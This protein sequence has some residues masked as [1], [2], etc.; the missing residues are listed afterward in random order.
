LY[1][2]FNGVWP[3]FFAEQF[4]WPVRYSGM[5]LGNQFGLVLA[6]FGP[7]IAGML[8]TPGINGWVPVATFGTICMLVAALSV[9]FSRETAKTPIEELG[10]PYLEGTASCREQHADQKLATQIP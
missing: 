6:G 1:S 9:F 8:L 10:A 5:A 3:A 4:A 7:M 2:G